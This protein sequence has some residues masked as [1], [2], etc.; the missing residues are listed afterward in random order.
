MENLTNSFCIVI[1]SHLSNEKRIHYLIECL[2]SLLKQTLPIEIYLSISFQT[3]QIKDIFFNNA[4]LIDLC[5]KINLIT[6]ENK[7]PQMRHIYL[8][9]P[10]LLKK[11]SWVMFCDDDD[12]YEKTR[13]ERI[14]Q[15]IY[16]GDQ[17]CKQ[18][19]K[20]LAGLYESTFG[21]DHRE[22]RHE[23]WCYCVNIKML[24]TF[25]ERLLDYPDIIDNKCCD[26]V[27]AEYL[28]RSGPDY[29]FCRIED[30][31]YKYRV[32]DNTDSITGFIKGNQQRYTRFNQKPSITDINFADYVVDWNECL[33]DNMDIYLHDIFLRTIVGCDIDYILKAEFR[34]DSELFDFVD[35][36]HLEKIMKKHKYWRGVCDKLFDIPFS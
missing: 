33:Y 8:L 15:N 1:A 9:C 28:R 32:D 23:Y 34:G 6:Q 26:V 13:V 25:Y 19:N 12:T 2:D 11:H 17:Q 5:N 27:F 21:K 16:S 20:F 22:H 29:L 3:S 4:K 36:C 7:T 10:E 24:V 31:L 18:M 30:Q 35:S 14:I